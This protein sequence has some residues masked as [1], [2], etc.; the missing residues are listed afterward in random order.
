MNKVVT[1][2]LI[3]LGQRTGD[4]GT[5]FHRAPFERSHLKHQMETVSMV[6]MNH[7]CSETGPEFALCLVPCPWFDDLYSIVGR[8]TDGMQVVQNIANVTT[9][10][11]DKPLKLVQNT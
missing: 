9:D 1:Y 2:F 5:S 3:Q 4:S 11:Q 7:E 8:V 10:K 6:R